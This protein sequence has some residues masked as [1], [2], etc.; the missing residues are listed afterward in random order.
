MDGQ[1]ILSYVQ[2]SALEI[3][4]TPCDISGVANGTENTDT[5]VPAFEQASDS[6]EICCGPHEVFLA[7]PLKKQRITSLLV[8]RLVSFL[9]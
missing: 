5:P 7:P 3:I 8:L 4:S 6:T 9:L 2:A 1:Q